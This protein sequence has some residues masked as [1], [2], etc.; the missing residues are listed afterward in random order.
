[1]VQ[2]AFTMGQE[3]SE[4]IGLPTAIKTRQ[5]SKN[6]TFREHEMVVAVMPCTGP[7]SIQ[8]DGHCRKMNP[9]GLE[10]HQE[11]MKTAAMY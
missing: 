11:R 7:S 4:R 8:F 9:S 1:M 5:P 10:S 2:L 6:S 3:H